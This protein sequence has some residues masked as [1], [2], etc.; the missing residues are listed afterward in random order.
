M[1]LKGCNSHDIGVSISAEPNTDPAGVK[2]ISLPTDPWRTGRCNERSPPVRE[3]T[4][5]RPDVRLPS[6]KR[7]TAGILSSRRTR[8]ARRCALCWG[9][10]GIKSSTTV[11]EC[12]GGKARLRKAK[13]V[14]ADGP[15]RLRKILKLSYNFRCRANRFC[16]RDPSS[17][18]KPASNKGFRL[19]TQVVFFYQGRH[20]TTGDSCVRPSSRRSAP[21][22]ARSMRKLRWVILPVCL[23]V[24]LCCA[25][26]WAQG[27]RQVFVS[28]GTAGP[29]YSIDTASGTVSSLIANPGA[30]FEGM[31]VAPYNV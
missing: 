6:L 19:D 30:D 29:I 8:S 15:S 25:G 7:T 16:N 23:F 27:A 20:S 3:T 11:C 18:Q 10:N 2:N 14:F 21:R 5:S 12:Q 9:I 24:C 17:Q 26:L 31:V 22:R 28:T 4:F 1:N 13:I